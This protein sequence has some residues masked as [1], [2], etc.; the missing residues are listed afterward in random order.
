MHDWIPVKIP[1]DLE[2]TPLQIKTDFALGSDDLIDVHMYNK[3]GSHIGLVQVYFS[4]SSIMKYY[5]GYCTNSWTDLPVEPPVEVDK[6]WT[7][8]KTESALIIICNN[9]EVLN[10]LFADSS[11]SDCV[12]KMGG[13]VVISF[14]RKNSYFYRAAKKNRT[15][16]NSS[17]TATY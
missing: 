2:A 6:I 8:T 16:L 3:D 7:I 5:I 10:Y 9:V 11:D 14:Y 17:S 15:E 4:P 13:D 12:P 1:F